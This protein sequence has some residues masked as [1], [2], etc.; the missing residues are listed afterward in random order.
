MA[1]HGGETC[2]VLTCSSVRTA[3]PSS[4]YFLRNNAVYNGMV[5]ALPGAG[6]VVPP[7]DCVASFDLEREEWRKHL[8]GPISM[9]YDDGEDS[10]DELHPLDR[11]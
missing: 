3:A 8:Q 5:A 6:I 10:D 2:R 1:A 11:R 7:A 9:G 4:V